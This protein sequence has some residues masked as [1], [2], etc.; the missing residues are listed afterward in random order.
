MQPEPFRALF[1]FSGGSPVEPEAA[2]VELLLRTADGRAWVL[3]MASGCERFIG[4]Y[5][6]ICGIEDGKPLLEYRTAGAF[7]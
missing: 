3:E 1:H 7:F 5:P 4:F 6:R 2:R